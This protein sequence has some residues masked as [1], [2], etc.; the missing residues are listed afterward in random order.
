[1][2]K[3][4]KVDAEHQLV[5]LTPPRNFDY[6]AVRR[7]MGA[8]IGLDIDDAMVVVDLTGT[9]E[10][11]TAAFGFFVWL[12]DKLVRANGQL[13]VTN[14]NAQLSAVLQAAGLDHLVRSDQPSPPVQLSRL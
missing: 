9:Q 13:V 6:I 11:K 4:I 8:F 5:T 2:A 7:Y 12:E 1:M 10:L 3:L 14:A